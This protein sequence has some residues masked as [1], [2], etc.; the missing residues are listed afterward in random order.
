MKR[1]GFVLASALALAGSSFGATYTNKWT[2]AANNFKF[3]DAGNWESQNA[4]VSAAQVLSNNCSSD[5]TIYDFGE[6]A[7]GTTITLTSTTKQFL[8]GF[9]I[10]GS[11]SA[12]W[13]LK[14]ADSGKSF[15]Y[16][17]T[18][19]EWNVQGGTLNYA[20][21]NFMNW[22]GDSDNITVKGGGVIRMCQPTSYS[23]QFWN[24]DL[25]LQN[26]TLYIAHPNVFQYQRFSLRDNKSQVILECDTKIVVLSSADG[27]TDAQVDL[28]GHKLTVWRGGYGVSDESGLY[29]GDVIGPGTIAVNGNVRQN[30]YKRLPSTVAFVQGQGDLVFGKSGAPTHPTSA[31][32]FTINM[33]ARSFFYDDVTFSTLSGTGVTGSPV[34]PDGKTITVAGIGSAARTE[35]ASAITGAVNVV[36]G[37]ADYE[38]EISGENGYSGTTTVSAGTLSLRKPLYRKGLVAYYGFEDPDNL[39]R[40]DSDGGCNLRQSYT[41]DKGK[42]VTSV[43]DGVIGRAA[44]FVNDGSGMRLESPV[45]STTSSNYS[46]PGLSGRF[47]SGT[48]SFTVSVWVRPSADCPARGSILQ[49]GRNGGSNQAFAMRFNDTP[50]TDGSYVAKT[51]LYI[52]TKDVGCDARLSA[53]AKF[54]D[55][56][57]HLWTATHSNGLVKVYID[58]KYWTQFTPWHSSFPKFDLHEG[59]FSIGWGNLWQD[60]GAYDGD[61]DELMIFDYPFSDDEVAA[62]YALNRPAEDPD[63]D[64]VA[65]LP[66]PI[67]QWEFDDGENLGKDSTPNGHD[68]ATSGTVS[69]VSAS[70][71][72]AVP[73][74]GG[75]I[76]LDAAGCLKFADDA[77][78]EDFPRGDQSFTVMARVL[79]GSCSEQAP[80]LSWGTKSAKH[81]FEMGVNSYQRCWSL[82]FEATGNSNT[83]TAGD[84]TSAGSCNAFLRWT[85]LVVTYNAPQKTMS[86]YMNGVFKQS[87]GTT[88]LTFDAANFMIGARCDQ[89]T[90]WK[91]YIDEVRL[92]DRP[93][94]AGEVRLVEETF[95]DGVRGP[96]IPAASE[97]TVASGAKLRVSAG[98][99]TLAQ[100]VKGAG[101]IEV[102]KSGALKLSNMEDFTGSLAGVGALTLADTTFGG[103]LGTFAGVLTVTNSTATLPSAAS[104]CSFVLKDGAVVKVSSLD[105]LP[106]AAESASGTVTIDVSAVAADV[107]KG[108]VPIFVLPASGVAE[109]TTFVIRG[110]TSFM[111]AEYDAVQGVLNLRSKFGLTL[112]VR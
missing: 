70:S 107:K 1:F 98:G 73:H 105:A 94:T 38:L 88:A 104:A 14:S 51:D 22:G 92:Y 96:V 99:H 67:A 40:D 34:L 55:G 30:F 47:P 24:S 7:D 41:T 49:F 28:G 59:R 100:G 9:V 48:N 61:I 31:F 103:S 5:R 42:R 8:S 86:L 109:G 69:F 36:K 21:N 13:S 83:M 102:S 35:F 82:M 93:L 112:L 11:G 27:V 37:G 72:T 54:D 3:D 64:P 12:V 6:L 15:C 101:A 81:M 68:L 89:S 2:G 85:T 46:V 43:A 84:D 65:A 79:A 26:V 57:W 17:N 71:T 76:S 66:D 23:P 52:S 16:R 78:P 95:W 29:R 63:Y 10:K 108:R 20:A 80:I 44:H 39:G 33:S 91:G 56:T 4:G 19:P 111:S 90:K 74:K 77:F 75:M 87:R 18:S 106:F 58:G 110:G 53:G 97:T 25:L 32:P 45:A 60:P 62:E 50:S